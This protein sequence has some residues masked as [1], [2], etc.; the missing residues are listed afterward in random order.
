MRVEKFLNDRFGMFIHWG[1]YSV[2][3]RHEWLRSH[4]RLT[5]EDYQKYIDG[6][7]PKKDCIRSW[8]KLAKKAG[9]KYAVLTTKHHDGFCLFK[10]QYTDYS[11][12]N[13]IGRDLVQEYVEAFR[14]E[15]IK[16]GFYFTLID[17]HHQDYPTYKDAKHPL[18]DDEDEKEKQKQRNLG[19]YIEYMHNQ[20]R[21]LLT[22][23]GKIDILW[24]DY[25]YPNTTASGLDAGEG[26]KA[27]NSEESALPDMVGETW[28]ATKLVKIV[29]ELQPG[30]IINNRLAG[31]GGHIE[32]EACYGGDFITP[33]KIIPP[34]GV[35]GENGEV[36]P[37]ES[38]VTMNNNWCYSHNVFSYKS[39]KTLIHALI[40]CAS[41]DGNLLL[42]VGP[43]AKGD[44]PE[45]SVQRLFEI[46]KWM[47]K[48][49]DSIYN[50]ASAP[51]MKPDWGRYTMKGSKLYAHIY[52][53][54]IGPI[55]FIGLEGKIKLAKLLS[56]D[57]IM[58]L[59][60]PFNVAKFPNDAFLTLPYY[61]QLPDEN[62]TVIELTLNCE[63]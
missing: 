61:D 1:A 41:K 17:W 5:I 31:N 24:F 40:E 19:N 35:V 11:T 60:R 14:A 21:E 25:S 4:E 37:W 47:E 30:I 57:V 53:C 46:G 50:C 42:N 10:S 6:F 9:M 51:L 36:I 56:D 63:L 12:Y 20:V 33:E 3:G 49:S 32:K 58:E 39:T 38:C 26:G 34:Q 44:I 43:T 54:G 13:T 8:A 45:E 55:P 48:N 59:D 16:I 27:L 7:N 28:E 22:N 2:S 23:Y 29:R 62:S 52:E 15:G 18:R